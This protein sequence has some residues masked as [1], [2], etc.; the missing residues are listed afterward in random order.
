MFTEGK[1]V[2]TAS[3]SL[4]FS[5]LSTYLLISSLTGSQLVY[6]YSIYVAVVTFWSTN[7]PSFV[8]SS[9]RFWAFYLLANDSDDDEEVCGGGTRGAGGAP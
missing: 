1:A 7:Y 2:Y 3:T 4:I 8:S 9:L 5:I 6:S